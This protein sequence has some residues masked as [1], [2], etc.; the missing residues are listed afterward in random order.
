MS[1]RG[2]PRASGARLSRYSYLVSLMPEQIDRATSSLDLELRSRPV[3]SY[4]PTVRDGA[5]PRP[6]RRARRG[7]GDRASRSASLTGSDRGV[8]RLA[9]VLRARSRELAEVG[10][11]HAARAAPHRARGPRAGRRADLGRS[12]SS[13]PLGEVD[14]G[15]VRR[16]HGARRG[17]DRRADRHL[18]RPARPVP[19][20]E[21]LLPLPPDRQRHRRVA[22]AG[23]RH[24][25]GHRRAAR[26][27]AR[28]AGAEIAHRRRRQRHRGR[29]RPAPRSPGTTAPAPT[30]VQAAAGARQRGPVGAA[31]PAGRGAP[32]DREA[33]G[34]AAQDQLP[35]RPA[36]PAEVRASTRASA[37]AGHAARRRGLRPARSRP[38][39]RRRPGELPVRAAGRAL[40]PLADRPL[41]PR[42]P[43]RRRA[44]TR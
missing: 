14:R 19:G 9:G 38:T 29:R 12:S 28:E 7:R 6:A 5:A 30:S 32:D 41:D 31:G 37:F 18:R 35:A 39:P 34:L 8:R 22:G 17:R 33:R 26:G 27:G 25:R 36:A 3:A 1:A 43:G 2:V 15:A 10:R 21:P 40:L 42:R 20:A 4:T 11:A 16:R 23:R 24:G 44:C 13:E